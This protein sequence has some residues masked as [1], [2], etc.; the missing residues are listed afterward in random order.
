MKPV[1]YL[2]I[3]IAGQYMP[4]LTDAF[5]V[6][7]AT[8][9]E[10]RLQADARLADVDIVLTNGSLGFSPAQI[11]AAP[12][13]KLISAF[14]VGIE[15]LP[16]DHARAKGILLSS[17]A[18]SN[19]TTVADH[20]LAL[21]LA[22]MRRVPVF[23]RA[24]HKGEWRDAYALPPI[25]SGKRVG[26][27]GM[28]RIGE[29]VARRVLGF[30][31]AVGYHTRNKR[32][33]LPYT[34]FDNVM[35]LATWCDILVLAM[36]GGAQTRHMVNADVLAALGAHGFLVNVAR[37]SAVD[38]LALAEALKNRTIA[39][40]G[41][42]VYESEPAKPEPLLG[43][44]TLVMSPHVAGYSHEAVHGA[45]VLFLDNAQRVLR[46]EPVTSPV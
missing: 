14:G 29:G 9:K 20:A 32:D 31:C 17:G 45:V 33:A 7:M 13:L 36:P 8:N 4:L 42:D 26:I 2:N 40:A 46:G 43:F 25:L 16:V 23:D 6:V 12:R 15:N 21:M 5:D 34:Y 24:V 18:G 1:L 41:L 28:G 19:A 44:D 37:G 3:P 35:S 30:D 10:E 27:V 11:D 22:A 38:T 39:G